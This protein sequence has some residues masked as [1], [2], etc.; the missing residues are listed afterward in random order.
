LN[1]IRA[2][3]REPLLHFVL[4]GA[5]LFAVTALRQKQSE[6]AEIRITAGEV[7]QLA[8]FWETQ[9]Q[10]K[11]TAEELRGAIEE[12]IDEEV[13]AREA[14]RLGL[15]RDDVII[16]RRL[17]QK[18]AF[19]SDDLAVVAEPS[20]DELREYFNAHRETY[21]TPDLYALRHVYFNPDR[22][23]TLDADAQRALQRLTRGG[24]ADEVGDPFMLPRELA[25]VSREDIVR[26]FGSSFA[27]AVTG[28]TPGSWNGPVRSPFGV[29][30]VKLESHTPSS[31]ARF[32][33][34]RDVVRDAFLAQKQREANAA[35]RA[36]LR[37]QYKIIVETAEGAGS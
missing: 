36:K 29:H 13:L 4:I 24:N 25:D 8:A 15:D 14:M 7:A 34:V 33:D 18:M 1:F 32:E 19:V 22:H 16:R 3:V 12:R 21:T 30:L 37:Q 35:L 9:A 17:A 20:E 6:H 23:T 27:D 31:A 11:P 10:R 26:D 5:L 28:S 2:A